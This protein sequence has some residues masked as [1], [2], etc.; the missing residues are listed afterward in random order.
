MKL[1]YIKNKNVFKILKLTQLNYSN[2]IA[3]IFFRMKKI[4]NNIN[5]D[6]ICKI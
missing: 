3:Q 2:L 4:N 5:Q 1:I 6:K